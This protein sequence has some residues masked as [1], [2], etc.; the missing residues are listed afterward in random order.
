[1]LA[2]VR[3]FAFDSASCADVDERKLLLKSAAMALTPWLAAYFVIDVPWRPRNG[4]EDLK[5][6]GTWMILKWPAAASIF[7]SVRLFFSH[8][9]VIQY[10]TLPLRNR[11][12]ASSYPTP[13]P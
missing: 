3:P 5:I 2:G 9:P 8:G 13:R 1:M 6:F 10:G 12:F 11:D 7:G 4:T